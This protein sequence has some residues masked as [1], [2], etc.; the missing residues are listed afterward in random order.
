MFN[1]RSKRFDILGVKIPSIE[2]SNRYDGKD[3]VDLQQIKLSLHMT[4]NTVSSKCLTRDIVA[5][6][7]P[8]KVISKK[9][10]KNKFSSLFDV[11]TKYA[12]TSHSLLCIYMCWF[13]TLLM[14]EF[15]WFYQIRLTIQKAIVISET[16]IT[17]DFFSLA[18]LSLFSCIFIEV[19]EKIYFYKIISRPQLHCNSTECHGKPKY[20][21]NMIP[22]KQTTFIF[23]WK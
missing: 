6:L 11:I 13:E 23:I 17:N 3:A 2:R 21:Y 4:K 12:H 22:R 15:C 20:H 19:K 9:K 5:K 1:N 10:V 14:K 16:C 18:F 7:F 8:Y